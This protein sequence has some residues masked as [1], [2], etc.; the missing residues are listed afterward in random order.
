MRNR[1]LAVSGK[2][3]A[4]KD[5]LAPALARRL[6]PDTTNL[7]MSFA[8]PLRKEID[9]IIEATAFADDE[10]DYL[11]KINHRLP[12]P[13]DDDVLR[14][15]RRLALKAIMRENAVTA[16]DHTPSM[17]RLLQWW[18]TDVRRASDPDY[19]VVKAMS[20]VDDELDD[21]HAVYMTD[22]RFVNELES[23]RND[24]G[25]LVRVDVDEATRIRR[26]LSRD[27]V[28]PTRGQ[29]D[30][31]SETAADDYD[32]FDVR[33]DATSLAVDRIVEMVYTLLKDGTY[34]EV[35]D[36]GKAKEEQR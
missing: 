17:R 35:L 11:Y 24:G 25:I 23:V 19:W 28:R 21:G 29:L 34:Q 7:R 3:G 9:M 26:I 31:V 30:H 36:N 27:G 33:I 18:G 13:P 5:T 1:L 4:G 8:T 16:A 22:A 15:A 20:M 10:G 14:V 2:M 12:N 6:W 32:G